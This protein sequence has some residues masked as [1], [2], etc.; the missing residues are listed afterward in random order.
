[1]SHRTARRLFETVLRPFR[2]PRRNA[3]SP[4]MNGPTV[5]HT[6]YRPPRPELPARV[7]G[8]GIGSCGMPAGVEV[9]R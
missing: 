3:D 6:G 4:H 7:P 1:M 9:S 8:I 5:H 2:R